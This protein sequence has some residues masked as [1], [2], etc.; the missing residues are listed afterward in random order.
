M[1]EEQQQRAVELMREYL[2]APK[3]PEGDTPFERQT[4]RDREREKMIDETLKPVVAGFLAGKVS[5]ADFKPKID[6]LNKRH[7]YWGFKG[8]K[9]QMFFNLVVSRSSD[10]AECDQELKAAIAVPSNEDIARSRMRNFIS[11]VKRIGEEWVAQGESKRGAPKIGSV[12]FFLSYFWQL[13]DRQ[14]WP[15][16]YTASVNA[17]GDLNLWTPTE[18]PAADYITYKHIHEELSELFTKRSG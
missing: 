3:N 13:Q 17:M 12:P 8:I 6:G 5:L 18:D 7:G 1:N 9:G 10:E 11:Y 4:K 2:A 15:V 14:T 16:Y